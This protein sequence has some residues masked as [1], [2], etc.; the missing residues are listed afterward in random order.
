MHHNQHIVGIFFRGSE[1]QA[2]NALAQT[3][4][5]DFTSLEQAVLLRYLHI[6]RSLDQ[7]E[8]LLHADHRAK[9]AALKKVVAHL[10]ALPPL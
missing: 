4:L 8:T 5:T 9:E 6:P 3:N 10:L 7:V 1:H 2:H